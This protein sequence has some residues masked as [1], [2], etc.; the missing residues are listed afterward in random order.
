MSI[1]GAHVSET[2]DHN[3]GVMCMGNFDVHYPTDAQVSTLET[4][5]AEQMMRYRVP[6]SRVY[7]HRELKTTECPGDNLQRHMVQARRAGGRLTMVA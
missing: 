1:E 4:F 3:L 5:V 6:V 2:N 7:T